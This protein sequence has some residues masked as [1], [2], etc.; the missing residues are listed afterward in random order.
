MDV[1]EGLVLRPLRHPDLASFQIATFSKDANSSFRA[2]IR[3]M[4]SGESQ[5]SDSTA[6]QSPTQKARFVHPESKKKTF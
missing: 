4:N 5:F 2:K 1:V 6:R 3:G